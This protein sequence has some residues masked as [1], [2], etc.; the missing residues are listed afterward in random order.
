MSQRARATIGVTLDHER[1]GGYSKYPW[2]ALRTNY[3]EAIA[4]AGG[5]PIGLPHHAALAGDFLEQIDALVITGGAFDVDPALYG[6]SDRHRTVALKESR[7]A[8][9]LAL[10]QGAL[11]R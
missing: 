2:Y 3:M 9:E 7:T 6:A 8:A 11:A 1:P 10:L 4:A 5:L